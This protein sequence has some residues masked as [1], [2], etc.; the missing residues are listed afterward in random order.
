MLGLLHYR[1]HVN[2][3]TGWVHHTAYSILVVCIIRHDFAHIFTLA[4]FMELPTF[5]LALNF[6]IPATRS[7]ELFNT[8]FFLTR[9][10]FHGVLIGLYSTSHGRLHGTGITAVLEGRV[11][12]VHHLMP[13]L[14]LLAAAPLHI[15]WFT[16]SMKG[17]FK[18]RRASRRAAALVTAIP[19]FVDAAVVSAP[20]PRPI[21]ASFASRLPQLPHLPHLPQLPIL[22]TIPLSSASRL[23]FPQTMT[24]KRHRSLHPSSRTTTGGRNNLIGRGTASAPRLVRHNSF[25]REVR[26]YFRIASEQASLAWNERRAQFQEL[27]PFALQLLNQ[28][29]PT[30]PGEAPGDE[31]G[32]LLGRG[33]SVRALFTPPRG[34]TLQEMRMRAGQGGAELQRFGG[35]M[36]RRFSG[37]ATPVPTN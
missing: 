14:S 4:A 6:M 16:G 12:G 35:R 5:V 20:A 24:E 23:A 15:Q 26:D 11:V 10:L 27:T 18:R 30:L 22:P 32:Q 19:A 34:M 36:R 17:M 13:V 7:D 3:L 31:R 21:L 8:L 2:L 28:T 25:E 1:Q 33:S 37:F 29:L 9:I